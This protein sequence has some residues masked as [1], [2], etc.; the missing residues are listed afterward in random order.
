PLR[1]EV[2]AVRD[3]IDGAMSEMRALLLELRPS[4]LDERGLV[5]ALADLCAAYQER[6]GVAIDTRLAPIA[7]PPPADH[8][9]LRVAREGIANAVRQAD[10]RHIALELA[11]RD[12]CAE[13]VVADDG[14]GFVE[15][16]ALHGYGLGLR[17]MRER[18]RELG[19]TLVIT[20]APGE[21][22]RV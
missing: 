9:V 18:V 22:T 16:A 8:A 20:T 11:Q 3:T 2:D 21:G 15:S 1:R 14:R 17:V 7:V 10:A 12:G 19:G 6:L 5:P 4:M 13:L